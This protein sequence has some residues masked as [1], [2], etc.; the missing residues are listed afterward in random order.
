MVEVWRLSNAAI[1]DEI[2]RQ[3]GGVFKGR[4]PVRLGDHDAFI[5]FESD[6]EITV[7]ARIK[8]ARQTLLNQARKDWNPL[9][10]RWSIP[11]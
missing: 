2:R 11:R 4:V 6:D 1:E 3:V 7:E 8:A 9:D 10:E 5:T